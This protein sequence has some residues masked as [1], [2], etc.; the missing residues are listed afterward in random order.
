[1]IRAQRPVSHHP[2]AQHRVAPLQGEAAEEVPPVDDQKEV[3]ARSAGP[4]QPP[5]SQE[6]RRKRGRIHQLIPLRSPPVEVGD[7]EQAGWSHYRISRRVVA[8]GEGAHLMPTVFPQPAETFSRSLCWLEVSAFLEGLLGDGPEDRIDV[9]NIGDPRGMDR[10][11]QPGRAG[12]DSEKDKR[13][14]SV[15]ERQAR[16]KPQA[17]P[18]ALNRKDHD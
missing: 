12:N 9:G 10:N 15:R 1:M 7:V 14:Q 16:D 5:R 2:D 3:A 11:R 4:G 17:V 8:I 6:G 18:S 13:I